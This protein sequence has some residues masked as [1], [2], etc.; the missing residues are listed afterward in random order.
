[1]SCRLAQP[2]FVVGV[3]L[4]GVVCARADEGG[5]QWHALPVESGASVLARAAGLEPGLPSWRVLYEACRRRHGLWG[6]DAGST[7]DTDSPETPPGDGSVPLPLAPAFWRGLLRD[8]E[9]LPDGRLALAILADRRSALLY[10]GLA[11]LDDETLAALGSEADALRR[12]QR[13]H[14]DVFAAFASRF[15]VRGGA[16]AVPGGPEA[17]AIWQAL[18]GESPK[19]P[20]RFLLKLVERSEG[21]L[22]FLYDSV[23]RLDP[24]RQRLALGLPV[25]PGTDAK[26]ALLALYGTFEAE[27]AWWRNGRGAFAR[28]DADAARVLRE[29]RLSE[30]GGLAPPASLAFWVAVFDGKPA[31]PEVVRESPRVDVAWLAARIGKGD[32]GL[33]RLRLEQ[34]AFAQRVFGA[35]AEEAPIEAIQALSGLVDTRALVLALERFGSRDPAFFAAAVTGARSSLTFQ[36]PEDLARAHAGLQGALAVVDRARFSGALDTL[37]AER[38]VRSL[39]QVPLPGVV[40]WER[41]L[42]GWVQQTL[43]PTLAGAVGG[44]AADPDQTVLRAMAGAATDRQSGSAF[45]WEGLW[46]RAQPERAE[47]RRLEGVRRRQG[48]QSLKAVLRECRAPAEKERHL[49]AGAMGEALTSLVYAVHLGEPDGPALLGED[50][51]RRHEFLPDAWALPSEVSGPG[52][53]WHVQGSLLGLETALARLSL[54]RVAADE[55][56]DRAPVIDAVQRRRL[57][58]S[59]GLSNPLELSDADQGALAAAVAS[60]RR[61]VQRLAPASPDLQSVARDAALDPWRARALEWLLEHERPALSAFFSLGELAYLGEPAGGRWDGWGAPD[62]TLSGLRLR[63]PLPR[64]LDDSSG[65]PPETPLAEGF[66]DLGVRVAVHLA[67]RGLPASLAPALVATLLPDLF[68]EARPVAPDDRLALDAW[69]REQPAERLD[70]AVASLVGRGPLQPAPAPGRTR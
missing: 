10:R 63:L 2:S 64:P 34:V 66:V 15:A 14:A 23:A 22:A 45:D 49:C 32:P 6:E 8:G 4:V 7:P 5:R 47:L 11:G 37:A 27:A 67:E 24:A 18:V 41:G 53:P 36:V 58:V 33:R 44:D 35:A 46:Y 3:A 39:L 62:P 56:P 28:P 20:A 69:A 61:R 55:L 54:H 26:A 12:I 1:M 68:V 60:G 13:R 52:V 9:Q 17:E 40:P 16:V 19:A 21:R 42:G 48:G 29:V 59:A 70:D 38:L 43:L 51:A 50:P 30:D 57:A 31:T 25:G 65:R